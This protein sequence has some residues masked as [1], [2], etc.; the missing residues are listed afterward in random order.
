MPFGTAIDPVTIVK[1]EPFE[2]YLQFED[3]GSP[4][5]PHETPDYVATGYLSI[6]NGDGTNEVVELTG[7]SVLTIDDDGLVTG[8]IAAEVTAELPEGMLTT[9]TIR[10]A[11]TG[12]V[13]PLKLWVKCD[14][15][16]RP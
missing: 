13:E 12:N 8:T 15:E 11:P 1:G 9:L 14:V 5:T 2:V 16:W 7:D 3:E 4:P 6:D 10:A